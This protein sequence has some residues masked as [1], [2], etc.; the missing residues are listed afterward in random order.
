MSAKNTVCLVSDDADLR[1][2][3][4][5][6]FRSAGLILI[7]L[8]SSM[9]YLAGLA[10]QKAHG[11]V[12]IDA[13]GLD[14]IKELAKRRIAIP[15]VV[16]V[17]S[18]SV[19]AAVQAVKAGAFDVAERS[20]DAPAEVVKRA[21][22]GFAKMQKLLDEKQAASERVASLTRRE[23][24]VLSLMVQGRP[25]RK[26]AEE[27]GISPKTLDIHRANLMDKMGARTTADLCRAHLLDRID[28]VHLPHVAG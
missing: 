8:A 7:S 2:S 22:A 28:A 15:V 6:S 12:V 4:T 13:T 24:Q 27:L 11:C 16:M 10:E 19:A 26:I 20:G 25:N 23:V 3:L 21:F 14:L 5:A 9:D 17:P 18:G 1:K